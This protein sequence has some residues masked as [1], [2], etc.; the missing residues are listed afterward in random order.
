MNSI[1]KFETSVIESSFKKSTMYTNPNQK[2]NTP[3]MRSC[4]S[5]KSRLL[6][7]L[8]LMTFSLL[9]TFSS[10]S[11]TSVAWYQTKDSSALNTSY[12]GTSGGTL[13]SVNTGARTGTYAYTHTPA[14]TTTKYWYNTSIGVVGASSGNA[15]MIYWAKA[16]LNTSTAAGT[17][18]TFRYT[19]VGATGSVSSSATTSTATTLSTT[20]WTRCTGYTAVNNT[21]RMYHAAPFSS[22]TG[23]GTA[24]V[25]YDDFVI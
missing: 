15:H 24:L 25:Y 12:F 17:T 14:S 22:S 7:M 20:V 18:P 10:K 19:T 11:Q 2:I 1:Q 6:M 9:S 5:T 21:T 3:S 4:N 8:M 23:N 13:S 16:V